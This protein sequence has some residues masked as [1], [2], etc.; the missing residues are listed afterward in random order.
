MR[1][2]NHWLNFSEPDE[3]D[4]E[5]F[6]TGAEVF[7]RLTNEYS[8]SA[9]ADYRDED[10]TRFGIT[11]GFQFN[12]ELKYNFRQLSLLAGVEFNTLDRRN[13]EIDSSLLYFR[14]KRFF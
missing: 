2:I 4:V 9:R 11:R 12:S 8:I 10:D 6:K 7:S 13:D 1:V 5:L 14:L 3:R